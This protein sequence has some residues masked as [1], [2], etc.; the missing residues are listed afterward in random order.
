M[1]NLRLRSWLIAL[2]VVAVLPC[3]G[4]LL[5]N[6]RDSEAS[7]LDRAKANMEAVAR[8]AAATHE[9]S[10]EGV[11]QI[12]GTISSGPSVRRYDLEHLC[13]EFISNV[14][15]ASPSYSNIGVLSLEGRARCLRDK[16][17]VEIDFSDRQYFK[18]ALSSRRF[19]VGE[20]VVG[21]VSGKKALTLSV[22]V[23]DYEKRLKGVAYVGLDLARVDQRFKALKLD[24]AV[25][26]FLVDASGLLLASTGSAQSEIGK[27]L[28]DEGL[29]A[30]LADT[31]VET[32]RSI[33]TSTGTALYALTPVE[34]QGG[35]KTF[36]VVKAY[37]RDILG[38]SLKRLRT[39]LL[40]L[41]GSAALGVLAAWAVARR[42]I[43]LP[44]EQLV[45]RMNAVGRIGH[46]MENQAEEAPASSYEFNVLNKNLNN[47][48]EQLQLHQAAVASSSDGIVICDAGL[49]DLPMVYVNPAFERMTGYASA[50]VLG[51]NCRFLQASDRDQSGIQK[52]KLA[53][54][55]RRDVDVVI[56]NYRQDG[57]MFWNSLRIA[58]V[59]NGK[60]DV[61]HFVGI[62]TDITNRVESEQELARFANYDWLTGL[63]NR[64]LLEDRISQAIE[65]AQRDRSEFAVAFIDLD[66][67][68]VFNDSIGHAAGDKILVSVAKRLSQVVRAQDT[69]SRLGGD[70]FVVV[71]EGLGDAPELREVLGRL[72]YALEDPISLEGQD[73]FI[74][75]SI[76]ISLFPRDG[77]TVQS[78]IQ[79]ADIAMYRAKSDGRGVVRTYEPSFDNGLIERLELTN[80]LR[81]GLANKEFEL[82]YQPKVDAVSGALCGFE[83]LVRWRRPIQGLVSPLQFIP[84]AEQTG[85]IV[86]LG[87]W[88]LEEACSQLQKWRLDERFDVPV[89]VN[90]SGIQFRQDDLAATISHVLARTGLPADRLHIEITE[91]VM[92]EGQES[93]HRALSQ[94][95]ERGV[96][97]ALDDFGTGYSSLSY[98]KR[99]PIDYVKIDRSF[100][101]DITTDPADAAICSA[102]VAMAHRIGM[103]VIAEGVETVEQMEFLRK[104]QC[105]QLQGYLIGAPKPVAEVMG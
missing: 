31:G 85:F 48:L 100:V 101:R 82:H 28:A 83:A 86:L 22:P 96:S 51:K 39:Q 36:V 68:K 53:L 32:I 88:V 89:A 19:T 52:M 103:K 11:R 94:I 73:Y 21:R 102:I 78:L 33:P 1:S 46:T 14:A 72:R 30:L 13:S 49:G 50:D 2:I 66:N 105:D 43:S 56:R 34:R 7:T 10:I 62:Q 92:I 79:R 47:M 15:A 55:A 75:A 74:A 65:R 17:A 42:K 16:E 104:E 95:R 97:I 40:A 18:E 38:P 23:F 20:Y 8:L 25:K 4:I 5:L 76:G 71:F 57:S 3:F 67:F 84:L 90:V 44:I 27:V 99:F 91:S 80:A 9:Q 81:K 87:R 54:A 6:H 41:I 37:E 64:K 60:G 24:P 45:R 77:E 98:L 63:P 26:V 70:E 93:L 59:R 69:V 29:R 35:S 61:T 58:P 12:L